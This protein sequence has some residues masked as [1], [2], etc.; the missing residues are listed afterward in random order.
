MFGDKPSSDSRVLVIGLDGVTFDLIEP[1]ANAGYLPNLAHLMTKAA[2]GRMQSTIPDHSAPAWT[3]FAT[4]VLPGK[5]GLYFFLG[6]SR[7]HQYFRPVNATSIR[8]HTLW[9]LISEQGRQVGTV[10]VPMTYPARPVNGYMITGLLSPD[11]PSAF[12]P[13][14]LYQEVVHHCGDYI[15][16]VPPESNRR[17]YL[18]KVLAG[19]KLRC[20]VAEYLM[21][22]HPVD[23]FMVVFRMID[24]VMHHYW[25]D[26]DPHHPLH[27]T[28]GKALIPDAILSG[29]RVLDDAVGRLMAKAGSDTTVFVMSD[30]G[31]RAE[32]RRF[33]V[34]KWLRDCG[35]MNLARGRAPVMSG[36]LWTVDQ[37]GLRPL[38]KRA[39]RMATGSNW[40]QP[41]VWASIDWPR[42]QVVYGPGP[43]LYINL[44]G[45]DFAG[46]V[47]PSEYEGLRD[48]LIKG[49]KEIR[50]PETKLP[51]VAEVHRREEIYEG[52][53]VE[54]APDLIPV[55]AEYVTDG[56]RWG[57]GF[58]PSP[59]MTELFSHAGRFAGVHAPDGIFLACGPHIRGGQL[60]ALHIADMAP[61][62]LYTLGLA[63]PKAMDGQVRT[64][65]FDQAY[66]DVHPI[67]YEDQ[68]VTTGGKAGRV[69]SAEDEAVIQSRLKGLG[70]L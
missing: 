52:E 61:T 9:E 16:E 6:P 3:T 37:L 34:N 33:A 36:V 60:S 20:Q 10:N 54:L 49:L 35:L 45:R 40:F 23:F 2:W 21:D 4:G 15:V 53:A 44:Q 26:M 70:Y 14:E 31:F 32:Y 38:A 64:E 25:A 27:A 63:V 28:L 46:V 22:H 67:V 56:R 68:D 19:M 12:W 42:T 8:S 29:Y 55:P 69:M 11:A 58:A 13:P 30:H 50:D 7:D 18:D 62:L 59:V 17:V 5:H 24:T 65:I 48:R 39:F 41:M 1:W 51:I 47:T 43:G 66:L 57:F